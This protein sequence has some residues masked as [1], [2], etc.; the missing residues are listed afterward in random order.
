[1]SAQERDSLPDSAR[2]AV[3]SPAP[4]LKV[5]VEL[6]DTIPP[7]LFR[8]TD[9]LGLNHYTARLISRFSTIPDSLILEALN[10]A[11]SE[12]AYQ[13]SNAYTVSE[14]IRLF[15][16][17]DSL[18]NSFF[19]DLDLQL[20]DPD[21]MRFN[22]RDDQKWKSYA[23]NE[24][25]YTEFFQ[26]LLLILGNLGIADSRDGKQLLPGWPDELRWKYHE[27]RFEYMP[28]ELRART[29]ILR[30]SGADEPA[31]DSSDIRLTPLN[32]VLT[33]PAGDSTEL[34]LA[35]PKP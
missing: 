34:P 8:I 24:L 9:N 13:H 19:S 7:D 27:Y 26:E 14:V 6:A 31:P 18:W 23:L 22:F 17:M 28:E 16:G 11:N 2:A 10:R 21:I 5:S 29:R 33:A 32:P 35:V 15:C 25:F 12:V 30:K 20:R 1:V 4:E 3:Q